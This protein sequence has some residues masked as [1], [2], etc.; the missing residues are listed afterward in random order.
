MDFERSSGLSFLP[1]H[2]EKF[3]TINPDRSLSYLL[4]ILLSKYCPML[5]IAGSNEAHYKD[6]YINSIPKSVVWHS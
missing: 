3:V 6:I 1:Q 4:L 5:L 2:K